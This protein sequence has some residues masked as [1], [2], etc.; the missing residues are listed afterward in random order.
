MIRDLLD[1]KNQFNSS[2]TKGTTTH[3][4]KGREIGGNLSTT[5][6]T[7]ALSI[8]Q[9]TRLALLL[10][11]VLTLTPNRRD[12]SIRLLYRNCFWRAL[13]GGGWNKCDQ[14]IRHVP[15]PVQLC[16]CLSQV[17]FRVNIYVRKHSQFAECSLHSAVIEFGY[18]NC[19]RTWGI[20][21]FG[22]SS[23]QC[24][25]CALGMQLEEMCK[26]ISSVQT[27]VQFK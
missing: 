9:T 15:F 2:H 21:C 17:P 20:I 11:E 6:I 19:T 4:K 8:R 7:I 12:C 27:P 3:A 16:H 13:V 5:S 26:H 1:S 24:M 18:N 14:V 25:Q 22:M 10:L 23:G